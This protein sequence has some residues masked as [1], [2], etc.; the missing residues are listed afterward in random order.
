MKTIKRTNFFLPEEKKY[1]LWVFLGL[2]AILL[3][4]LLIYPKIQ[5]KETYQKLII[6]YRKEIVDMNGKIAE[7]MVRKGELEKIEKFLREKIS[8]KGNVVSLINA[9]VISQMPSTFKL[10]SLSAEKPFGSNEIQSMP[11]SIEFTSNKSDLSQFLG[12]LNSL[13]LPFEIV[14]LKIDGLSP[15]D[16]SVKIQLIFEK[17]N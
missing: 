12:K 5:K 2:F 7:S 16:I 15:Q 6:S 8:Y 3:L 1:L 17:R 14:D 13:P 11:V 9:N 10:I 4:Q